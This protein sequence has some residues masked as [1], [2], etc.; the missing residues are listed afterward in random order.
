MVYQVISDSPRLA[1]DDW[2]SMSSEP[3]VADDSNDY[4][5]MIYRGNGV[6]I[7]AH[8]L[9]DRLHMNGCGNCRGENVLIIY[10]QWSVSTASGN[11]YWDYEMFCRD[12]GKYTSRSFSEN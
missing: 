6:K 9:K 12:C 5:S 7:D 10:A 4:T 8:P 3:L 1:S 2:S 11:E